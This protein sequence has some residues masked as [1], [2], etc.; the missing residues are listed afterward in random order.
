MQKN[1][2]VAIRRA[3]F[4]L[5]TAYWPGAITWNSYIDVALPVHS[6]CTD[7]QSETFPRAPRFCARHPNWR[8]PL[9]VKAVRVGPWS[10]SDFPARRRDDGRWLICLDIS[11]ARVGR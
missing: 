3:I 11:R 8:L 9:L 4:G 5:A 7:S 6:S 1:S 10:W 2:L